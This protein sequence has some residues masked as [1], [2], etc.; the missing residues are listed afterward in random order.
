MREV[1]RTEEH[2]ELRARRRVHRHEHEEWPEEACAGSIQPACDG[3]VPA[4]QQDGIA[5]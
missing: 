3:E 5:R 4:I 1:A 2:A